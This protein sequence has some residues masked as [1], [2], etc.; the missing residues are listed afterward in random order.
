MKNIFDS[1]SSNEYAR[2]TK[3]NQLLIGDIFFQKRLDTTID[4]KQQAATAARAKQPAAKQPTSKAPA[5]R[6]ATK[7]APGKKS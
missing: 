3:R 2:R 4:P 5:G 7:P 1:Q 6:G